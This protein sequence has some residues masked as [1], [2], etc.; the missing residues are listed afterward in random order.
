MG[1]I[2]LGV[3]TVI[4]GFGI[5]IA[6]ISIRSSPIPSV[7]SGKTTAQIAK[8][9]FGYKG[10]SDTEL[11][12]LRAIPFK[13]WTR[14]DAEWDRVTQFDLDTE[15]QQIMNF[16]PWIETLED[17]EV[18]SAYIGWTNA[19]EKWIGEAEEELITHARRDAETNKAHRIAEALGSIPKPP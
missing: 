3:A 5:I 16:R 15:R 9:P 10:F 2:I 8:Q 1:H 6:G 4:V 11:A 7:T 14:N 13:T 17:G 19:A 18:K 12:V